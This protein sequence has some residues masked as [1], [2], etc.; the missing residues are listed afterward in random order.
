MENAYLCSQISRSD[1]KMFNGALR[2]HID[3]RNNNID[4]ISVLKSSN[5][6]LVLSNRLF[7]LQRGLPN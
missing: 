4:S 7:G 3:S 6:I 1:S 2:E 5:P